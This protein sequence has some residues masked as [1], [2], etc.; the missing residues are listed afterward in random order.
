MI[1]KQKFQEEVRSMNLK[2][3]KQFTI[4]LSFI[5]L[6]IIIACG[7]G[8]GGDSFVPQPAQ[9]TPT[10]PPSPPAESITVSLNQIITDCVTN[11]PDK[12]VTAL[13]TVNDQN[14][15]PITDLTAADFTLFEGLN[16]IPLDGS[17][18]CS[19]GESCFGVT[20][21]DQANIPLSVALVMDFSYSI[22]GANEERPALA[23]TRQAAVEFVN[24]LL[25]TDEAEI[26]KFGLE[27]E[28]AIDF[29]LADAAGKLAL[30]SA[31]NA[32][33]IGDND[34]SAV[35]D[36]IREA[37]EDTALRADGRRKAIVV[38]TD[39]EDNTSQNGLNDVLDLIRT[40][41][42]DENIP[43]FTIGL[44]TNL[45]EDPLKSIAEESGGVYFNA[46]T[47]DDLSGIYN[48]VAVSLIINQYVFRYNSSLAQSTLTDLMVEA[49][50]NSLTDSDS[51]SF[52]LCQ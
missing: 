51:L 21:A 24:L 18:E 45:V 37:V 40:T 22:S 31:I 15:N 16:Q 29:T 8:G 19:S 43:I 3:R 46:P 35:F 6:T 49:T 28:V 27:P 10:N 17:P 20:F 39:G 50:Y 9:T 4:L 26:I 5:F 30:E 13:V 33:L 32:S 2:V 25:P 48:D 11:A 47:I 7:G 52:T 38:L 34:G 23:A 42:N 12:Q 14:G 44:G 41:A 36:A 1:S